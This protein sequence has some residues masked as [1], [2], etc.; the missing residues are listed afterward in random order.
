MARFPIWWEWEIELPYHIL[1][2]M[3]DRKFNEVDLRAMLD[4]A[5][6]LREDYMDG[7]WIIS[8]RLHHK[9]WEVIVEPVPE[10]RVLL[11]ITAYPV[12]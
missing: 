11:V 12:D 2:R 3:T 8:T 7:R 9:R 4:D 5:T 10:D 1:Q 6:G